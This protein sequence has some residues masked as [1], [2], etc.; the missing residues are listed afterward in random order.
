MKFMQEFTFAISVECL[1]SDLVAKLIMH[2]W[3]QKKDENLV[4]IGFYKF[5]QVENQCT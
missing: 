2:N 1:R 4:F 3:A 5:S